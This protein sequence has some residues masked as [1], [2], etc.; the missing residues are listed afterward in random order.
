MGKKVEEVEKLVM[1]EEEEEE[2]EKEQ[3]KEDKVIGLV[4]GYS[5]R[6]SGKRTRKRIPAVATAD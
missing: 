4:T 5:S 6:D 1:Q 2:K 3:E